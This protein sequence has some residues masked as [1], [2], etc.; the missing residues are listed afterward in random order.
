MI[1]AGKAQA[2]PAFSFFGHENIFERDSKRKMLNARCAARIF[3][4]ADEKFHFNSP[5]VVE[6]F[7]LTPPFVVWNG[8]LARDSVI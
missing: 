4:A 2:F 3:N 8:S 7:T 5:F 6:I 1:P